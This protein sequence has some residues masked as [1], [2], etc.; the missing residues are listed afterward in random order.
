[1]SVCFHGVKDCR[2]C[3]DWHRR[4]PVQLRNRPKPRCPVCGRFTKAF[5]ECVRCIQRGFV[6]LRLF[7][8][9]A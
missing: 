4:E 6:A 9:A 3:G 7:E 5:V 8:V 2:F 1:M